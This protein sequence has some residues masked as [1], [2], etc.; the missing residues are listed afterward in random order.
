MRVYIQTGEIR[1]Q[2]NPST[3]NRRLKIRVRLCDAELFGILES[4][5][6][7]TTYIQAN[8]TNKNLFTVLVSEMRRFDITFSLVPKANIQ[9]LHNWA[10]QVIPSFSSNDMAM[11]SAVSQLF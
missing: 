1:T 7:N 10:T 11:P 6:N 4:A 3:Y 8:R 2:A 9:G 5:R